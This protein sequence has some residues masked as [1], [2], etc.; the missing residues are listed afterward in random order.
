MEK[1]NLHPR[2]KHRARY[3]FDAL[4]AVNP[5]LKKSLIKNK[6]NNEATIDFSN[7]LSVK[8]LNQAI[9][10]LNYKINYWDIPKNF[11]CPP[12]PGRADYIHY[13]A[14][15]LKKPFREESV[16]VLDIGCGANCVYPLV[17]HSEYGWRFVGADIDETAVA[18]AQK[19]VKENNLDSAI[20]IRKQDNP[21]HIFRGIIKEG[22][23]FDLSICNPPFHSSKEEAQR[24]TERK[25]RNLKTKSQLNFGGQS[26]EL[27]CPGGEGE[28]I[29][30][31]IEESVLY[32]E[33]CTWFTTLV[34]SKEN[35]SGV[36]GE[37]KRNKAMRVE[38][39]EMAQG[40]KIS[41]FVAWSFKGA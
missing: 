29:R 12:I 14:D 3:D 31:M 35:L 5:E 21:A 38:T 20:E 8:T 19:I 15:L 9:L 11:L 33:Q 17:G 30:R 28:F 26:N 23:S 41:R 40:Q 37:L 2:N 1:T 7:P 24:G 18:S 34:S 4:C 25:N 10:K 32:K 22:E 36:Y 13:A 16:R 27:W 39:I 6:Y